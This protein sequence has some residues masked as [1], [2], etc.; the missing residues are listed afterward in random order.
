MNKIIN[1]IIIFL[2]SSQ[3]IVWAESPETTASFAYGADVSWITQMEA[4]GKKFYNNAGTQMECMTLLKS[5]G[6]NSIRL[7]VW[8][9]PTGGWNNAADVLIKAKRANDL[10]LRLMIDFHYSD[11][12]ADPGKQTKPAA[13]TNLSFTDL[14][15]SVATHTSQ[16]LTLLKDNSITP[17]WVQVGNE[18]SNG[19]LWETGKASVS[20]SNYAAL[21]TSGYD[22]VKSVFPNAKVIVHINNGWD[23]GLFRWIFDGL[24]NNGGKWDIIGMSLYPSWYTTTND[25]SNCNKACLTNMNDMVSRYGKEVMIVECGMS[26]D[27][28]TTCKS[29]LTDLIAKTKTVT[30]GKGT[31]V[32]YWEPQSYG[33]WQGY[34]LGAF[35]NSGK[36]TVAMDAFSINT[37]LYI[38]SNQDYK[39]TW[40]KN[41]GVLKF[42][43]IFS[44]ISLHGIDGKLLKSTK[45]SDFLTT[46]GLQ[47]N[48]Y[49]IQVHQ[50]KTDKMQCL[51]IIIN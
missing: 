43:Q 30:G 20:M 7:R 33:Q 18:T 22:A 47:P 23:N 1:C 5:L 38:P 25:W 2:I 21:T 29:F 12:W 17:E 27:S 35:D 40:D 46:I 15:T 9:N 44:K 51:K 28:P 42:N 45:N 36:P 16:V 48:V 34:S 37:D 6:I 8:V 13:W 10:G 4:S 24:K 26:W 50:S 14:K 3:S 41:A 49:L 32:F 11:T 31:G 19:M 39:F